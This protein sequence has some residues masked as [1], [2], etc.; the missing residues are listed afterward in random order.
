[1]APTRSTLK[2]PC[3]SDLKKADDVPGSPFSFEKS[4]VMTA[5]SR[6]KSMF[7]GDPE[8]EGIAMCDEGNAQLERTAMNAGTNR[9]ASRSLNKSDSG[10]SSA[11]SVRSFQQ[12]RTRAS[13]DSQT[14]GSCGP[15]STKTFWITDDPSCTRLGDQ[16]QRHLSLQRTDSKNFSQLHPT[17]SR[18]YDCSGLAPESPAGSRARRSTLCAPRYT[19]YPLS[20]DLVPNHP[21]SIPVAGLRASAREQPVSTRGPLYGDR[22]SMSA[23][24]VPPLSCSPATLEKPFSHPQPTSTDAGSQ[25]HRSSSEHRARR[26]QEISIS[27]S[28]SRSRHG[29]RVWSHRPGIEVPPLPTIQS[30]DHLNVWEEKE[31]EYTLPE[32]RRG[33]PRSRSQDHRRR[34]LTKARPQTEMFI[35]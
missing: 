1:M 10:Y 19:E 14:S 32:A 23:F 35:W 28:W 31:V 24:D 15:D 29:S 3:V 30:P 13:F 11:T 22:F 12:S 33:R 9:S 2:I 4:P 20:G 7:P 5:P 21:K 27:H 17:A 8:D 16:V 26:G 25:L 18:W 6:T 34:R